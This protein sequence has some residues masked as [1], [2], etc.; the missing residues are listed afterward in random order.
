MINRKIYTINDTKPSY[1]NSG[2]VPYKDKYLFI[3]NTGDDNIKSYGFCNKD[4]TPCTEPVLFTSRRNFDFR[5]IECNGEYFAVFFTKFTSFRG[6]IVIQRFVINPNLTITWTRE[7][8]QLEEILDWPSY[9]KQ[10]AEKN[11]M[12]FVHHGEIYLI[13]S[14]LPHIILRFNPKIGKVQKV[15][16]EH[17]VPEGWDKVRNGMFGNASCARVG[18]YFLGTFHSKPTRQYWTGYYFFEARPPFRPKLIGTQE[19]FA[20]HYSTETRKS[21]RIARA[22]DNVMFP[23]GSITVDDKVLMSYGENDTLQRVAEFSIHD[24]LLNT[25]RVR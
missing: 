5:L 3:G 2:I 18:E 16:D 21:E 6:A 19:I 1:W 8:Y 22:F 15:Y 9:T 13:Y 10:H 17:W 23:I 14:V 25:H 11:W 7:R 12:P 20:P 4:M 24:L